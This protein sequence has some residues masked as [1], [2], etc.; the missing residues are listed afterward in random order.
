MSRKMILVVDDEPNLLKSIE[1]ALDK[2]YTVMLASSGIEA[3][4]KIRLVDAKIDLIICDLS[5]PHMN[6][7]DFFLH[8]L[9][10]YPGLEK[11]FIFM[12]GGPFGAYLS[13]FNITSDNP[14]IEKPFTNEDLFRNIANFFINHP[15]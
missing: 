15:Q 2:D 5:M 12:T 4:N 7:A 3:L 8:V 10:E 6:G 13:E 9:K 11:R 14:C 1:R